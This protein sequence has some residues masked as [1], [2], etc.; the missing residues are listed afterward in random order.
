M[1]E[2]PLSQAHSPHVEPE[3]LSGNIPD[4]PNSDHDSTGYAYLPNH[5][6]HVHM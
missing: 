6:L 3:E 5:I 2:Y 1:S 4:E